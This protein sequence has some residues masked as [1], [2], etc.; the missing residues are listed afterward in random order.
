MRSRQIAIAALAAAS[1]C[2]DRPSVADEGWVRDLV[3]LGADHKPLP[4]VIEARAGGAVDL[5]I[6][7]R[8]GIIDS[9]FASER[10]LQRPSKW[11]YRVEIFD[12]KGVAQ[13]AQVAGG[14]YGELHGFDRYGV[15]S[16]RIGGGVRG[17]EEV[18]WVS[19]DPVLGD[20]E[21][22]YL[23]GR[24]RVPEEPG[25]YKMAIRLFPTA[26][27]YHDQELNPEFGDPV[28]LHELTLNVGGA[29]GERKRMRYTLYYGADPTMKRDQLVRAIDPARRRREL[30]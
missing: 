15:E 9:S 13:V 20:K 24:I 14:L 16:R 1:L 22:R 3:V 7:F 26:D 27:P 5:V 28:D 30:N 17:P 10:D 29:R 23:W 18:V 6:G 4:A 21:R 11:R 19:P 8:L 12:S 2:V 25:T